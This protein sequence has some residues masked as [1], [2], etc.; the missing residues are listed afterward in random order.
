MMECCTTAKT[1]EKYLHISVWIDIKAL[2]NEEKQ[3]TF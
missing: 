2:L 3:I 1:D